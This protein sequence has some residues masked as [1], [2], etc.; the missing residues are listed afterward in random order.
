[1][2]KSW[3]D[4]SF[5]RPHNHYYIDR[6]SNYLIHIS[7]GTMRY[8][9]SRFTD[10][11]EAIEAEYRDFGPE[12]AQEAILCAYHEECGDAERV[13]NQMIELGYIK[14]EHKWNPKITA[15]S[16]TIPKPEKPVE[17]NPYD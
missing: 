2:R 9:F 12:A 1:M 5:M 10:H 4:I 3:D 6:R 11:M 13:W 8:D 14:P 15:A 7:N 16:M 17:Y